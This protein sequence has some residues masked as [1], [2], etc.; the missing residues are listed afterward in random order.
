M[1]HSLCFLLFILMLSKPTKTCLIGTETCLCTKIDQFID[2]SCVE[3]RILTPVVLDLS[4]LKVNFLRY[5]LVRLQIKSKFLNEIKSSSPNVFFKKITILR[6][7]DCILKEIKSMSFQ[8]MTFLS[9]L[10]LNRNSIE[11]IQQ[12]SFAGLNLKK[13]ELMGNKIQALNQNS[14]SLLTN[15]L[16][17]NLG[18]NEINQL[19]VQSFNG[20]GNLRELK[21]NFNRI[22]LVQ[23]GL[24]GNL[25][26]LEK[27]WLQSNDINK[28]D[29]NCFSSLANLKDLDIS[30]NRLNYIQNGPFQALTLL[31]ILRINEND[32]ASI[33]NESFDSLVNLSL[34]SM[35]SNKLI[36]IQN[37]L[38]KNL[39]RLETLLLHLNEIDTIEI[40]SLDSLDNLAELDL[41]SNKLKSIKDGVF[42]NLTLLKTLRLNQNELELIQ[43]DSFNRL[44]NLEVLYLYSNK[45]SSIK[46][47]LFENLNLLNTLWLQENLLETI[48]IGAFDSLPSLGLLYLHSNRLKSIQ[49]DLF[50][51]LTMLG[52]LRLEKNEIEQIDSNSFDSLI[53]LTELHLFS[54]K[55]TRIEKRTLVNLKALKYLNLSLNRLEI[56]ERNTFANLFN[57]K[58]ID[59]SHNYL[60]GF[61]EFSFVDLDFAG[62]LFLNF[63]YINKLTQDYLSSSLYSLRNLFLN[64]NGLRSIEENAFKDNGNLE[65]LY[66]HSNSIEMLNK[67][68]FFNLT[69]LKILS[70]NSNKIQN[71]SSIKSSLRHLI[72][73][74]SIDLSSN[75]IRFIN[76]TDFEQNLN[77]KSI[78]LN[79]NLINS[80]QANSFIYLSKLESFR[81]F[82]NNLASFKM[83]IINWE[84]ML[85]VDLGH[86]LLD[87]NGFDLSEKNLNSIQLEN[88]SLLNSKN[89]SFEIFLNPYV[90]YL[91]F[92]QNFIR[93]FRI[94]DDLFD[95][96]SIELRNVNLESMGQINF[97][98]FKHLIYLDLSFN[99][100]IR[101]EYDSFENLQHIEYLDLSFNRISSIDSRIFAGP[102]SFFPVQNSLI[103]LNLEQNEIVSIESTFTNYMLLRVLKMSNNLFRNIPEFSVYMVDDW[104]SYNYEFYFQHNNI[105]L[106]TQFSVSAY[107]LII[108]NFDDN[109]I[110]SID[111]E[112]FLNLKSLQNLS[113]SNNLLA[114][115]TKNNFYSLYSLKY[116][117]LSHN[118]IESI[119]VDSFINL[120][121]LISLDL[122]FNS[123]HSLESDTFNGLNYL[124]DLN[125]INQPI[126]L[127]LNDELLSRLANLKNIYL[128]KSIGVEEGKCLLM[129][130]SI[131]RNFTKNVQNKFKVYKSLNLIIED[132]NESNCDLK[133]HF[134]QFR[135]HFNLKSDQENELF[136]SN[137]K[138]DLIST[139]NS[140]FSNFIKCFNQNDSNLKQSYNFDELNPYFTGMGIFSD[141]LFYLTL[142]AILSLLGPVSCLICN[143]FYLIEK[144]RNNRKVSKNFSVKTFCTNNDVSFITDEANL[145]LDHTNQI[146]DPL[147]SKILAQSQ[148]F[149]LIKFTESTNKD[150][151]SL[152]YRGSQDGFGCKS[153]LSKC[154]SYSK[155]LTI[156]Q[157]EGN[158]KIFGRFT[159]D[160]NSDLDS[161]LFSIK[162]H[163]MRFSA[164]NDQPVKSQFTLGSDDIFITNSE[165]DISL[166]HSH[167]HLEYVLGFKE[168]A[169]TFL[170]GL[171]QFKLKEVEVYTV[172]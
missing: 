118:R 3:Y 66:L 142:F 109:K 97:R 83:N 48:E 34:L 170:T 37:G 129:K 85:E 158:E 120:N 169:E 35:D 44:V 141:Y 143:H 123:L 63:N 115:L 60:D 40:G 13:L 132:L 135:V 160:N 56:I 112:A 71:L 52:E 11:I 30:S 6:L 33:E 133:F 126:G 138:N 146:K 57:L 77:L 31:E 150:K 134:L 113:M 108:L 103:Y 107:T 7:E 54:N 76:D 20:L 88:V 1:C 22:K 116:L 151:W 39:A 84:N 10:Y 105:S 147:K 106:I 23:N 111:D 168:V 62:S 61:N 165:S 5:E 89:A 78:N 70:L 24:F 69:S 45:L 25:S 153:F 55:F 64:N 119:G 145:K 172:A 81:L 121:N 136:Y 72:N 130:F 98:H 42:R 32:I 159:N 27:L 167:K 82:K 104:S 162:N 152:I 14:F 38:L 127:K 92:S 102:K 114:Y 163:E 148:S 29:S 100:L 149:D 154:D 90:E 2:M 157:V 17:L 41:S 8:G 87:F 28:L 86:A 47:G 131:E 59:L 73:L 166:D 9:E 164:S 50:R 74:E 110:A 53:H 18:S 91:D 75:L 36:K 26:M 144:Q 80:I 79:S 43:K 67:N 155:A 117:N 139:D 128:D 16:Y 96:I 99:N 95:L 125:L 140:F 58:Y 21:L 65:S 68:S 46:N 93:N 4:K 19:N 124:N 122:S 12:N 49:G 161:F 51:K 15:L 101:L 156:V 94:F 171:N 137:C